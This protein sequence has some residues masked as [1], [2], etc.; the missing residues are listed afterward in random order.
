MRLHYATANVRDV[1]GKEPAAIWTFVT[2]D[3]MAFGFFFLLFMI[4]RSHDPVLFNH[5]A[6][7]LGTRLGMLNTL[8]LVTSGWFMALAVQ[9]ARRGDRADVRRLLVLAFVV[10]GGFAVTKAVEYA[11][12]IS[13]GI[14]MLSNEF[15]MF[16]FFLTGLHFFHF[17]V[18]MGVLAML[19]LR[20]GREAP[21]GALCGWIESG[22]IYWHMVDLLWIM[23][24]P[25]LYL[26]RAP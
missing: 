13:H 20:V 5:S 26:L 15:F 7:L 11:A 19:W 21:D 2:A 22:G 17:L 3:V 6:A 12:K 23:L 4:E 18:G 14:T 9:A 1:P 24:F 25:L 8:I 16:Y 10:G